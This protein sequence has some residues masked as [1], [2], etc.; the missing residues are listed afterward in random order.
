M[1]EVPD[2][3][4]TCKDPHVAAGLLKLW[5]RSLPQP[6]CTYELYDCFLAGELIDF[7]EMCTLSDR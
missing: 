4:N 7:V 3:I 2:L 6:L 1:G 5:L